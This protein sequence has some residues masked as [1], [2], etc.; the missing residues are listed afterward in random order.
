M[1]LWGNGFCVF[2]NGPLAMD[3]FNTETTVKDVVHGSRAYPSHPNQ[4]ETGF[5]SLESMA[6]LQQRFQQISEFL[7]LLNSW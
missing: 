4:L 7:Q 3:E 1:H 6:G 5:F 2:R